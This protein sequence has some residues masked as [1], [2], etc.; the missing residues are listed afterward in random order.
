MRSTDFKCLLSFDGTEIHYYGNDEDWDKQYDKIL[1][2]PDFKPQAITGP[3]LYLSSEHPKNPDSVSNLL[4][5][6]A[7][8]EKQF[9]KFNNAIHENFS[10]L[11]VLG[12]PVEP[13]AKD[14][15]SGRHET[16]KKLTLTFF[17]QYLKSERVSIADTIKDL[18]TKSSSKYSK[19]LP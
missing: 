7:S 16:V 2:Q 17:N 18:S 19:D 6:I 9:L 12:K 1:A 15:D 10:S 8:K 13:K 3:Y 4:K 11:P 5:V 14:L